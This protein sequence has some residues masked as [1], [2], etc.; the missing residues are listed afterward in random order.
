MNRFVDAR[1]RG[2]DVRLTFTNNVLLSSQDVFEESLGEILDHKGK[3]QEER[4][5]WLF[6]AMSYAGAEIW[7]EQGFKG[8]AIS[9]LAHIYPI[10]YT[11]IC[12]FVMRAIDL[13]LKQEIVPEEVDLGLLELKKK[14]TTKSLEQNGT[15][16][17]ND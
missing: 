8:I 16:R 6:S 15:E 1:F 12:T 17:L 9:E 11:Q 2:R 5:L 10:E 13:G 7:K 4:I 3:K 14:R